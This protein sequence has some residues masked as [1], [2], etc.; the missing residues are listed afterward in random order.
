M[1]AWTA[2]IPNSCGMF[3]IV[4]Q[5]ICHCVQWQIDSV[6]VLVWALAPFCVLV[7]FL[8]FASLS[9]LAKRKSGWGICG[10]S[11]LVWWWLLFLLLQSICRFQG[12]FVLAL[13]ISCLLSCKDRAFSATSA[14]LEEKKNQFFTASHCQNRALERDRPHQR[15]KRRVWSFERH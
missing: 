4:M 7:L 12:L 1:S 8:L 3:L 9:P 14:T 10:S 11:L 6:G 15:K 5:W 2:V 13:C